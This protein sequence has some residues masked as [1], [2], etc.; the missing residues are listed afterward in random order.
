MDF[1]TP[2]RVDWHF[3]PKPT[4]KGLVIREM[5]DKQRA[6]AHSLLKTSLSELGYT[7]ATKIMQLEEVL[8]QLEGDTDHKR[9]DP[10]KYY[11]TIFGKPDAESRRGASPVV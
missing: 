1:D 4:R 10:L 7:K 8:A 6:A 9:R 5:N 3:I 2:K 11:F